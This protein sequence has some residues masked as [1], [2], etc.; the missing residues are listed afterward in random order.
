[1]NWKK[2]ASII[3]TAGITISACQPT[4][5]T[6]T[7]SSAI[8]DSPMR[9]T[10]TAERQ[11][12]ST[13]T[14]QAVKTSAGTNVE[15]TITDLASPIPER[16]AFPEATDVSIPV[17]GLDLVGTFYAPEKV[18]PPWPGVI[19]LHMLY[20]DRSQWGSFPH[21]LAE[22]GYSVLSVDLRG[23]GETGGTINWDLA[24]NDLEQIWNYL[25]SRPE[26]DKDRTA[27]I[28][29]SIGANLALV[30]GSNEESIITVVLLSP[31]LNYAGVETEPAMRSF[32]DRPVLIVASQ[33]DTYAADSS[34][35]LDEAAIGE[36]R[37]ILFEGAGHGSNMFAAEP[38]LSEQIID[39]LDDYL[40]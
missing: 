19:L 27:M 11:K 3:F 4:T 15:P 13:P 29:A 39:W 17:D 18:S 25:I 7:P 5:I 22:S 34:V 9:P 31:G 14:I 33:E 1:M 26:I 28:G 20:S 23:H 37:L 35:A 2:V 12:V 32:G 24:A 8:Q 16:T 10:S 21:L 40:E 30:G 36:S 6:Q 38:D